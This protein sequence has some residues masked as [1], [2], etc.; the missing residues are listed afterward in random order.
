[1]KKTLKLWKKE[2][3]KTSRLLE[4]PK[5]GKT[6][7]VQQQCKIKMNIRKYDYGT[8]WMFRWSRSVTNDSV[9]R[10]RC[11]SPASWVWSRAVFT[12]LPTTR[13]WSATS[14]SVRICT[15]TPSCPEVNTHIYNYINRKEM[16]HFKYLVGSALHD[17]R[18]RSTTVPETVHPKT[19]FGNILSY[20]MLPTFHSRQ[21]FFRCLSF[22]AFLPFS[23]TTFLLWE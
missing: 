19:L 4:K 18:Y 9:A 11:S 10:R 6:A 3:I 7:T 1:M 22:C 13:S 14:T 23:M 15:P 5:T 2:S 8:V 12:R 17:K 21:S 16:N 20:L